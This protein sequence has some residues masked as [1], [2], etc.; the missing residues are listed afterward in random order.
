[1]NY[2][3]ANEK[4]RLQEAPS[5]RHAR[6]QQQGRS[7][8]PLCPEKARGGAESEL[9]SPTSNVHRGLPGALA[10][11]QPPTPEPVSLTVC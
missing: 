1:M 5:L 6:S 4:L 2:Y 7:Q 10:L 11:G 8:S 3:F 9:S